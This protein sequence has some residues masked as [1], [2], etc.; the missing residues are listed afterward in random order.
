MTAPVLRVGVVGLGNMGA[1]IAANLVRSGVGVI[2]FDPDP[3]R[4]ASAAEDGV[5]MAEDV[6]AVARA[7]GIIITSLPSAKV[8]ADV[9]VAILESAKAPCIV[10]ETSTLSLEDKQAM[11]RRAEGG[12]HILL[13]CPLS[14]TSAQARSRDLTVLAS[15]DAEAL[16][17][18]ENTLSLIGRVRKV[19]EFGA[20][21]R[22]KLIANLLVAI[23]NVSTAECLSLGLRSGLDP[24]MLIEVLGTGAGASRMLEVRGPVMA[25]R[26][27]QP[28][29]MTLDLW[30]KDLALISAFARSC[31][32]PTPLFDT[33]KALYARTRDERDGADDTAAV[34]EQF[35]SNYQS[36]PEG[37]E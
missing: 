22:V 18:V 32:S 14:G 31:A 5:I 7:A 20:G 4:A 1:A 37:H 3:V 35:L 6:G 25:S 12:L 2:G 24:D 34:F 23:H 36:S 27:Y 28:A 16:A 13:D 26:A 9:L 30:E 15:G 10:V 8:A 33:V 19:G 29:A 17:S 11:L 21:T